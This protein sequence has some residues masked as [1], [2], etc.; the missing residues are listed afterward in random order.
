MDARSSEECG[1]RL[2][3]ELINHTISFRINYPMIF[4][5]EII[6]S[7]FSYVDRCKIATI[8]H[9]FAIDTGLYMYENGTLVRNKVEEKDRIILINKDYVIIRHL[10]ESS[11]ENEHGDWCR[12]DTILSCT[13]MFNLFGIKNEIS[14]S[15]VSEYVLSRFSY[16]DRPLPRWSR[17]YVE[18]DY[19][20][21]YKID[22]ILNI[23]RC[24]K[25]DI[26]NQGAG[27]SNI[28]KKDKILCGMF[29]EDFM[30]LLTK[31]VKIYGN[32]SINYAKF[33]G[34]L[35]Y[36]ECVS[37][38]DKLHF[39][40]CEFILKNTLVEYSHYPQIEL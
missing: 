27:F 2:P 23:V 12:R 36:R 10:Y 22:D 18:F 26:K 16:D 7:I 40:V 20:V 33:Q 25:N 24:K 34:N 11:E 38:E 28:S 9:Y 4:P 3:Q 1:L 31:I 15:F 17:L 13:T 6:N 32:K 29:V 5:L 8:S 19:D 37:Y 14:I 21:I 30:K 35:Q 39:I